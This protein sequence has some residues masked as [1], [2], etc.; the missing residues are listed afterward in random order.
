ML[1][2]RTTTTQQQQQQQ[3]TNNQ[4]TTNK[5]PTNN[6]QQHRFYRSRGLFTMQNYFAINTSCDT[7]G[8]K[9]RFIK[10]SNELYN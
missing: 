7:R 10:W 3:T 4:Q 9:T 5:Q 6:K 2:Q 1:Q 8:H